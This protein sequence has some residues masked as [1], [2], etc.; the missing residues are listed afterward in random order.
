MNAPAVASE[1]EKAVVALMTQSRTA[2]GQAR[3]VLTAGD[4][5]S[6]AHALIF[7]ACCDLA[8]RNEPV[9]PPAVIAELRRQGELTKAGGA[10]YIASLYQIPVVGES[11]VHYAK[12]VRGASRARQALQIGQRIVQVADELGHDQ[13]AMLDQLAADQLALQLLV[14]EPMHDAKIEGLSSWSEFWAQPDDPQD[15]IVPNLVERQDVFLLLGSE[16]GGKSYMTRQWCLA[17]AAGVHPFRPEQR[18][19]PRRTLLVDLENAESMVR[20]QSRPVGSQVSRLGEWNDD[21]AHIWRKPDGLNLRKR[22]D[23]QLLERVVAETRPVFV[24]LGSLY[25]AF[26]R[27]RDDWDT[28]AAEAIEVL[29]RIR[30]RYRCAFFL[31]HHMPKGDGKERPQTP[32][33]SSEWMRW[34]SHGRVLARIG[35]NA[36][37]LDPSFRGDRDPRDIPVGLCRGGDLPWTPIWDPEELAYLSFPDTKK[38][39]R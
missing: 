7:G 6:P 38:G 4:L 27:G 9:E 35:E 39:K 10:T 25:K 21:L 24:G 16:G 36:Y 31:E 14:D 8:E 30:Y 32:F 2:V 17:I 15:W 1:A 33:G 23:A 19:E 26:K 22:A 13:D 29:D 20:R 11:L 5:Y 12:L 18:I 37:S 34:A 3:A 28:A